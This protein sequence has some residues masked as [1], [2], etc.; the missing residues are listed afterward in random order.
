VRSVIQRVSRAAVTVDGREVGAIATGLLIL[1]G[2]EQGDTDKDLV[3]TADKVVNLRIFEDA[4]G[5]MNLSVGEVGGG[6][7][8]VPNFTVAGDAQKGRRP[9]FD[10]AM[11]P[12][13][14]EDMFARFVEAVRLAAVGAGR[15]IPV[16]TGVFRAT[17]EVSLVNDGPVT[18]VISSRAKVD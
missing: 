13:P 8:I 12:A 2:I 10:S 14:A 15:Q 16:A 7:L 9:S 3:W 5:K 6:I 17:M 4:Q 11:P 1:A 18:I